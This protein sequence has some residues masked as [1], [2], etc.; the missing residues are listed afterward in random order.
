MN[1][2]IKNCKYTS[3]IKLLI[4]L[5]ITLILFLSF[6]IS[7]SA[8]TDIRLSVSASPSS[9]PAFYIEQ[10]IGDIKLET[11]IHRSRNIV[12]SRLMK[13]EVDAALLSTNEAAKLYN[14]GVDVKIA[15]IHTW[16]IFYLLSSRQDI[17]NWNDLKAK[18]IYVPDKGGPLDIVFQEL[19]QKNNLTPAKDLQIQRGKMR[20]V[21]QLMIN[22]MAETAVLREPFVSQTLLNNNNTE[23]VFD[24]QEEWSKVYSFRIPQSALIFRA[25]FAEEHPELVDKLEENYITALN[26]L[27]NNRDTAAD[28]GQQFLEVDREIILASYERLNLEYK[29]SSEVKN[30]IENYL[31]TLMNYSKDTIGGSIPDEKFYIEN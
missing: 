17:D 15:G 20:E 25:E 28:L 19:L 2:S 3:L 26:Y 24:L 1:Y 22:D 27:E 23:V 21:A 4:I 5:T 8:Q 14:K 29:S 9:L 13:K 12:I 30:D 7:S 6:S 11:N 18:D 10:N 31:Q 16:G